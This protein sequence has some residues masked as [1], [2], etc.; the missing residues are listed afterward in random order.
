MRW[1]ILLMTLLTTSTLALAGERVKLDGYAEWRRDGALIVEGQVVRADRSTRF[2]GERSAKSFA[3]IPAGYEVKVAGTRLGDGSVRASKVE[4]K[5]NGNAM[6]EGQLK[7]AFDSTEARW[8]E[9]GRVVEEGHDL[10]RLLDSGAHVARARRI[11][12]RL[13]PPYRDP[14]EFR[15]YVVDN[16]EWNAMAAPNGSVYVFRGLLD[17]MDDDEVAIVIGHEIAHATHEHSRKQY[18]RNLWTQL[19]F[20]GGTAAASRGSRAVREI[21]GAAVGLGALAFTNHYSREHEDQADRVGLRYAYEGGFDVTK[22]PG[23]WKKFGAKYG[24]QP[25]ALNFFFGGHSTPASRARALQQEIA[26]NYRAR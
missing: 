8:R 7:A 9:E 10:G 22:A 18:K 11:T 26:W 3:S 23:L 20:A 13:V 24:S 1:A 15:V 14:S 16:D 21:S 4:A 17:A 5:P 6:F 2:E 12:E 19:A 25:E